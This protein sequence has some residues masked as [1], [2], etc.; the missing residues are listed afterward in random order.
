M[1][2]SIFLGLGFVVVYSVEL[3][4]AN[5]KSQLNHTGSPI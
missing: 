1:K 2:P 4:W 5:G 3:A